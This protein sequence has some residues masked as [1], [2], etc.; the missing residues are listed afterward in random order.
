MGGGNTHTHDNTKG[1]SFLIK[2][3]EQ[4]RHNKMHF[5]FSKCFTCP[6]IWLTPWSTALLE[7]LIATQLVKEFSVFHD[8]KINYRVPKN[9]PLDPILSQMNPV[10]TLLHY[11]FKTHFNINILLSTLRPS[12][13]S[14]PF[15]VSD[16]NIVCISH[17]SH[18][19][20]MLHISVTDQSIS[21]PGILN[22]CDIG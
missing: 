7:K 15:R 14:L 17:L 3:A 19:C 11:T 2:Q 6:Q 21:V 9:P 18:A 16:R 8:P 12:K 5:P 10:H 22:R 20:Y 1:A 13:W 4:V